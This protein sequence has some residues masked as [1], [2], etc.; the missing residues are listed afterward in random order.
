M[1]APDRRIAIVPAGGERSILNRRLQLLAVIWVVIAILA[2]TAIR[3]A[4]I[5]ALTA[6]LLFVCL[7]QLPT[8]VLRRLPGGRALIEE[9]P[10]RIELDEAGMAF[11]GR[12]GIVRRVTWEEISALE[13]D[14]WCRGTLVGSGGDRVCFVEPKFVRPRVGWFRAPSL[15]VQIV[16]VRPDRYVLS[17]PINRFTQPDGFRLRSEGYAPPDLAAI[18]RRQAVLQVL[19]LVVLAAVV[20]IV[21]AIR[22]GQPS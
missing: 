19:L 12:K 2:L 5:L 15:A 11:A 16:R 3:P 9:S 10:I 14:R 18:E 21:L 6:G 1:S 13:V 8:W 20:T 7:L 17:S 4:T 22:V